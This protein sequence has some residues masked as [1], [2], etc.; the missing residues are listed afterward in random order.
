ML[1]LGSEGLAMKTASMAA[2]GMERRQ[3]RSHGH[4]LK[5]VL[6]FLLAA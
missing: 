3:T 6:I 2:R 4:Q 1:V 5:S